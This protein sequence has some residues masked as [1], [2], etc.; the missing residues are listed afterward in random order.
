MYIHYYTLI[1]NQSINS[2]YNNGEKIKKN[3][4]FLLQF[5]YTIIFFKVFFFYSFAI[6][7]FILVYYT[8]YT[9]KYSIPIQRYFKDKLTNLLKCMHDRFSDNIA[10]CCLTFLVCICTPNQIVGGRKKIQE[11]AR[12]IR[13]NNPQ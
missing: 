5:K 11:Q 8:D 9:H 4:L 6:Y 10:E 7:K 3:K 1:V 12:A 2:T 13:E